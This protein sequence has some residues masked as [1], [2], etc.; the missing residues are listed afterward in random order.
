MKKKYPLLHELV[1]QHMMHGPCGVLNKNCACMQDGGCRFK[2]PKRFSETTEQGK[3]AYSIYR[4]RNDGHKVFVHKKWLNNR[5][6]VPYNLMLLMRYNCHI[7]VEVCSSIKCCK[8]LYK[9]VYKG[10]DCASFAVGNHNQN[11]E[12]EINEIK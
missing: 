11:E 9:Y 10:T 4:R 6:V 2:Y 3:D 12:I 5:W 1:Y 7:N 8:Y